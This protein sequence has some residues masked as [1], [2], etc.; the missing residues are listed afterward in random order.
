MI[1]ARK[2]LLF[3]CIGSIHARALFESIYPLLIGQV[4]Q[5]LTAEHSSALIEGVV[6]PFLFRRV[7]EASAKLPHIRACYITLKTAVRCV[8][9]QH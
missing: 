6:M 7:R 2:M 1:S 5:E 8:F 3:G 4:Q 9:L